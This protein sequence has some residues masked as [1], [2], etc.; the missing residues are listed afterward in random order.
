[1]SDFNIALKSQEE[2]DKINVGLAA[3]DVA[4]KERLNSQSSMKL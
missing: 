4:Y 3:S 1:M 2:R